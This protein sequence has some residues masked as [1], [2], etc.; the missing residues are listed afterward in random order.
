MLRERFKFE[1]NF[2]GD[3]NLFRQAFTNS[4][5]IFY[6]DGDGILF[7]TAEVVLNDFQIKNGIT[8]NPTAI[9]RWGYL[10]HLA[11]SNHLPNEKIQSAEDGWYD[12]D[13]LV[14]ARRYLFIKSV[15]RKTVALSGPERNYV[16]TSREPILKDSTMESLKREFPQIPTSNLLIRSDKNIKPTDYKASVVKFG[17]AVAPWVVLIDDSTKY[18]KAVL[19][20]NIPN[21]VVVNVPLGQIKPDFSHPQ[22]ITLGRFPVECQGMYALD[23][24]IDRLT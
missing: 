11:V 14:M 13:I 4:K 7:N 19:D 12:P 10:T 24:A 6:Y 1:Q 15:V 5:S 20:A 3:K 22:M 9:D 2:D 18:C 21:C 23:E 8:A 16:L 17:S